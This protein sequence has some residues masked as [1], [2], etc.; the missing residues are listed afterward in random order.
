MKKNNP[1]YNSLL[2]KSKREILGKLGEGFNF[3]PD[4]IW[5]YELNK[6]WWGVKKISLLLRFEQ[7][8]VIKA[9]KVSYYGKLRLK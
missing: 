8:N 1:E 4:D 3:F 6:T 9:K 5:I 7:D 2:G